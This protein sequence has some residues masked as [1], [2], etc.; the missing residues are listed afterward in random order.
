[1]YFRKIQW[2]VLE[3]SQIENVMKLTGSLM[4][5][6]V[7]NTTKI[8]NEKLKMMKDVQYILLI[9]PSVSTCIYEDN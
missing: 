6:W 5:L 7:V 8:S 2:G 4:Q 3:V 9:M 1:L